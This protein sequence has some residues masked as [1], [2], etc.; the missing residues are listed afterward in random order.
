MERRGYVLKVELI[1][2]IDGCGVKDGVEV[3]G[4]SNWKVKFL[5]RLGGRGLWEEVRSG[6]V[7][8]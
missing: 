2:F 4:L 5:R 8:C 1:G 7:V 3:F 6:L